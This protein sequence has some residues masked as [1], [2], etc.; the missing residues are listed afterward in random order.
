MGKVIYFCSDSQAAIKALASANSRSKIVIACRTQIEEL[1]S[2]NA[3]H[4]VW[5]HGHSSIAG[6]ELADELA[7]SGAS[8]V[9]IGNEFMTK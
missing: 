7:R 8:H 1:N 4:L 3:V 2:A 6:N 9:F 5:V